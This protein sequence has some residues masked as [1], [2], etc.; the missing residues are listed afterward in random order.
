MMTR[1]DIELGLIRAL[2]VGGLVLSGNLSAEDKR[3]RIRVAIFQHKLK[4]QPFDDCL[5]YGE[6]FG[7]CFGR[8]FEMG[9]MHRDETP[10]PNLDEADEEDEDL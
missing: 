9:R 1:E 3:E 10:R 2:S 7:Q 6:A 5:T 4:D 8:P